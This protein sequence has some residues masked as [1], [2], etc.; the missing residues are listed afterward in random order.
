MAF[1]IYECI[2]FLGRH[3]SMLVYFQCQDYFD[4]DFLEVFVRVVEQYQLLSSL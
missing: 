4:K 2:L 3:D 1:N